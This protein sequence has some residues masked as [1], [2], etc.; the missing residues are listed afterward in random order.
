MHRDELYLEDE[1]CSWWN[2]AISGAAVCQLRRQND[3]PT[4]ADSHLRDGISPSANHGF[5]EHDTAGVVC[6]SIT[7]PFGSEM[8]YFTVNVLFSA[9]AGPVPRMTS[10]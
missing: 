9:A 8:T 2:R 6:V 1:G 5:A 7:V 10:R 4:S 3:R